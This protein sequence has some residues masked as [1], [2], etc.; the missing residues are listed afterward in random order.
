MA[1]KVDGLLEIKH[2]IKRW[3]DSDMP[4]INSDGAWSKIKSIIEATEK[5]INEYEQRAES[6]QPKQDGEQ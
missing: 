5:S 3:E 4:W 1:D 6:P 2:V